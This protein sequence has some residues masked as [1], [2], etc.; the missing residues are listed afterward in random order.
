M[1]VTKIK[2]NTKKYKSNSIDSKIKSLEGKIRKLKKQKVKAK[3]EETIS[4]ARVYAKDLRSRATTAERKFLEVAKAKGLSLKFQYPIF[5][6]TATE[7]EKFYIADFCDT[8]NKIVFEI[9]GEYHY[10]EEQSNLDA[11]RTKAL[12]KKGYRVYRITNNDVFAGKSTALLY[13]AYH[14]FE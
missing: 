14:N 4:I 9:D 2:T 6:S 1:R 3:N 10:S 11:T 8:K 13:K 7:I 12:N 5:I